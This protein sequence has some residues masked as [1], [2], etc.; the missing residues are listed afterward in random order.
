MTETAR[1]AGD[2][3]QGFLQI[4]TESFSQVLG[5]ISG[6]AVP[7]KVAGEA[8]ADFAAGEGD[9]WV[10]ITSSGGLR[11]EM[12]LRFSSATAVRLAQIFTG[13]PATA[14][15]DAALASSASEEQREA[16]I[17][18][19][20]QIAGIVSTGAKARWGEIQLRVET[21]TAA[22]TWPAA[23]DFWI[24]W[25][26]GESSLTLQCGL[27]AALAA[28]LKTDSANTTSKAVEAV[29]PTTAPVAAAV[30]A[31][32]APPDT[33]ALDLLMDVQL[34]MTLRFGSKT[35]LLRDVLDLSPGSVVELDRKVQEPIDLLLEGRLV[36]RGDLVV[37]DGNYGLR[38]TDVSP[39]GT[40]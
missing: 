6:S 40:A 37:I 10:V 19:L 33:G 35:L 22:P 11:G 31:N 36:A 23:A 14:A 17:E 26:E 3:V 39:L 20:R 9:V 18:L 8:P 25:G 15:P 30:S 1:A 16:V 21:A 34:S 29:T 32:G 12:T 28:E 38:V 5:Q 7:C 4:W 27:S 13:E 2:A 24:E